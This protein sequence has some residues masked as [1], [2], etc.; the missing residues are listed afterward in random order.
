VVSRRKKKMV[1]N[2]FRALLH[3]P[4]MTVLNLNAA[5]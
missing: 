1:E 2:V 3:P 5:S 4:E